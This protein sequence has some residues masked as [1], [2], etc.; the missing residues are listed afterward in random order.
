MDFYLLL[1][2]ICKNLNSIYSKK[3]FGSAKK[4]GADTLKTDSKERF[5][6]QQKQPVI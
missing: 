2:K 5:K 3:L 4:S 6:K 1:K